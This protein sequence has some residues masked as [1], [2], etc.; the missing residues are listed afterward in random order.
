MLRKKE[1]AT[2]L[3]LGMCFLGTA[4]CENQDQ[5]T[6]DP[7]EDTSVLVEAFVVRISNEAIAEADVNPIG[8]APEGV[9]ILKI[10]WCLK[11]EEKAQVISGAKVMAC[12]KGQ[13]KSKNKETFYIKRESPDVTV[14]PPNVP[15]PKNVQIDAYDSNKQFETYVRI[16]E[17]NLVGLEYSYSEFGVSES[18]D[19]VMPPDQFS[20]D[21]SGRLVVQSGKPVIAGAI[22]NED[23]TTFLILTA[24]VQRD[25]EKK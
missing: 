16:K 25:T 6:P 9:S 4:F 5:Q 14:A 21:W 22:Q 20:Y 11:D 7:Y 8:Q 10:L 3:L 23:N 12:H 13:S 15:T 19:T 18:E 17:E 1:M 2:I 24:T